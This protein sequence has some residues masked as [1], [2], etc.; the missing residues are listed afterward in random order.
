MKKLVRDKYLK[1]IKDSKVEKLDKVKDNFPKYLK[2]KFHE[3]VEEAF[4]E[5]RVFKRIEEF[6]DILTVFK[7]AID[8]F[9]IDLDDVTK[10]YEKKEKKFGG[11]KDFVVLNKRDKDEK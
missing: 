2:E 9:N 8:Y 5:D 10:A 4:V 11:F 6:A 1:I 7:T 3:E